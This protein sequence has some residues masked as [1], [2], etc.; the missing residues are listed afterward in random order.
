[1]RFS[2]CYLKN[3][4]RLAGKWTWYNLRLCFLLPKNIVSL[5]K[6]RRHFG[7]KETIR[8]YNSSQIIENHIITKPKFV[9]K[10]M[11]EGFYLHRL[12]LKLSAG[13]L[14]PLPESSQGIIPLR[15]QIK[16]ALRWEHLA[17]VFYSLHIYFG[18]WCNLLS[19]IHFYQMASIILWMS[20]TSWSD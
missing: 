10:E 20:I 1:M 12:T 2:Y 14:S 15:K 13:F 6:W 17:F 18:M 8:N 16:K 11:E 5:G 9:T 7:R 3:Q 19:Y 4:Q